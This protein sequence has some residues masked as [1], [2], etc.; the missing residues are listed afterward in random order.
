LKTAIANIFNSIGVMAVALTLMI[1]NCKGKCKGGTAETGVTKKDTVV[2]YDHSVKIL[3]PITNPVFTSEKTVTVSAAVDTLAIIRAYL[4]V[5]TY[6]Q[7]FGDSSYKAVGH[8][9]VTQNQLVDALLEMQQLSPVRV[10]ESSTVTLPSPS[11]AGFY[12]G[13]FADGSRSQF[14]VGPSISFQTKK[15]LVL[16]YDYEAINRTH[17]VRIQQRLKW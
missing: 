14:G 5:R 11:K 1:H 4:A 8:F 13:G 6:S 9:T 2:V 10:I 15:N 3:Q 16:G 17:R 12:V 7:S